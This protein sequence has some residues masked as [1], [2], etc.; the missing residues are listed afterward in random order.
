MSAA[1][2]L[3]FKRNVTLN[4]YIRLLLSIVIEV[5][6]KK[7]LALML[8]SLLGLTS[9]SGD[10]DNTAPPPI[11]NPSFEEMDDTASG[12]PYGWIRVGLYGDALG[13]QRK[14]GLGFMPTDG[15]Y[16]LEFPAS[17]TYPSLLVYQDDVDLTDSIS[18]IFDYEVLN[19]FMPDGIFGYDGTAKV[20]IYFH[21]YYA[22]GITDLWSKEFP[23]GTF[24][25]DISNPS[26]IIGERV[27]N[28][29]VPVPAGLGTGLLSIKVTISPNS[30]N[31]IFDLN[32]T[33]TFRI[34]NIHLAY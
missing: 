25:M 11:L 32:P 33:F 24:S 20:R 22:G 27:S 2:N 7:L 12:Q 5:D 3:I 10:R 31:E 15:Q 21:S 28:V 17:G 1:K 18:L 6:M 16:F 4:L 34:D 13:I 30:H 29:I 14:A 9:C 23:S 19:V 26:A 8:L